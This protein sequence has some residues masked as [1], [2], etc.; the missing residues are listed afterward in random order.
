MFGHTCSSSSLCCHA[1]CHTLKA[2][3]FYH[4]NSNSCLGSCQGVTKNIEH[5]G[6][7]SLYSWHQAIF[8]CSLHT[9]Q[10]LPVLYTPGNFH[11]Y[12]TQQAIFTCTLHT[13]QFSPVPYILLPVPY[14][15][16]NF[17]HL[18]RLFHLFFFLVKD[19]HHTTRIT[20]GYWSNTCATDSL[21]MVTSFSHEP[22]MQSPSW[23]S[24]LPQ[25]TNS[26]APV[27]ILVYVFEHCPWCVSANFRIYNFSRT[28]T[29]LVYSLLFSTAKESLTCAIHIQVFRVYG[30]Y[31]RRLDI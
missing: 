7:N 23:R 22:T 29:F 27:M 28:S 24:I 2:L 13:R 5:C 26:V 4:T 3:V 21:V 18:P 12:S 16:G 31:P 1:H 14:T 25:C 6:V 20:Q 17:H 15:Q 10:F 11:L 30:P 9:R 19:H 8:I